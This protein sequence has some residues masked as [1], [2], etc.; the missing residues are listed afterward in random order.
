MAELLDRC[1]PLAAGATSLEC[2]AGLRN[3]D[4]PHQF[5]FD[6]PAGTYYFWLATDR[7]GGEIA[8]ARIRVKETR[9]TPGDNCESAL[10][11]VV[12]TSNAVTPS[13]SERLFAPSCA[14]DAPLTWYRFTTTSGMT[15][16]STDAA[17]AVGFVDPSSGAE[18]ACVADA[19]GG[20]A[21]FA[22]VGTDVC[23][24]VPSGALSRIDLTALPYDG[25]FGR[26]TSLNIDRPLTSTGSTATITSD[27]WMAVTPSTLY[28]G[29][30]STGLLRA[31]K[32]GG[33]QAEL[34][35]TDIG[36]RQLG[37]A[38]T[39]VGE[40]VFSVD[41]STSLPDGDPYTFRLVGTTGIPATEPWDTGNAYQNDID[42]IG[43]DGTELLLATDVS[44]GTPD[45]FFYALDPTTPG[46]SRSLGRNSAI[47]DVTAVQADATW[48]Y[49]LGNTGTTA[50]EGLYRLRRDQLLD[51]SQVP[52]AIH[53]IALDDARAKLFLHTTATTTY[54]YFRDDDGAVHVVDVGAATP[55]YLGVLSEIG[56][57]GDDA[58][59]FDPTGPSLYLFETESAT[60]GN[61]VRLD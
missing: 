7:T 26:P 46:S 38:G 61:F 1:D 8:G 9:V 3:A 58:M 39:S 31:P 29:V 56:R 24:A 12:G 44:T 20:R 30:S 28:M 4:N 49:V 50:S 14:P 43:Y 35:Q 34:L 10:P 17:A 5:F 40:A 27:F 55:A 53:L 13:G 23:V 19:T 59:A 37:N 54:A 47:E 16:V 32:V 36:S 45:T 42:A 60:T 15:V 48:V 2:R 52:E 6:G 25:V 22:P 41:E 51:V 57:G 21:I 18:R 11:L 33:V